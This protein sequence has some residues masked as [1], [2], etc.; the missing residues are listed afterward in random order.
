[1][2]S[3]VE[4]RVFDVDVHNGMKTAVPLYFGPKC[5]SLSGKSLKSATNLS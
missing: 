2:L 1:M 5:I 4:L 3:S